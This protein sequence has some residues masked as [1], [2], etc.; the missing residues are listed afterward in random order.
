MTNNTNNIDCIH[1][2]ASVATS[3]TISGVTSHVHACKVREFCTLTESKLTLLDGSPIAVCAT[4]KQ[5][6]PPPTRP[7]ATIPLTIGMATFDDYWG[8]W[9]TCQALHNARIEAGLLNEIE[10][11]VVDNNPDGSHG[12]PTKGQVNSY[13]NAR[14]IEFTDHQG[15]SGPRNKVFEVASG[16]G[17]VVIDPH[18]LFVR[19]VETLRKLVEFWSQPTAPAD[20]YHGPC[21]YDWLVDP[22]GRPSILG[23]HWEPRW[24]SDG[25]FGKWATAEP[26]THSPHAINDPDATPIEVPLNA[27]G[28]FMSARDSW[29][30]F[31]P[32]QRGF[33]AEEGTIHHKYRHH[34]R[35]TFVLPWLQWV[36]RWGKVERVAYGGMEWTR[37]CKNY[38]LSTRDFGW[39]TLGELKPIFVTTE[40][41][42]IT[43][44][45]DPNLAVKGQTRVTES[46]WQAMLQEL[47]LA[48]KGTAASPAATPN[49]VTLLDPDP[50]VRPYELD[51]LASPAFE[52]VSREHR[53][54]AVMCNRGCPSMQSEPVS[55]FWCKAHQASVTLGKRRTD[56]QHCLECPLRKPLNDES[57]DPLVSHVA[58]SIQ[59]ADQLKSRLPESTLAVQGTTSPRV[60][61]LL[62]NL[63]SAPDVRYL[64]VGCWLGALFISAQAGNDVQHSLAV[65]DFSEFNQYGTARES[66][67]ANC[68]THL[69]REP[70]LIDGDANSL[71][72]EE[73][74][75]VRNGPFNVYL[76]DAAHDYQS[77]FNAIVRVWPALADR[78]ILLVDDANL[79][80]VLDATREALKQCGAV[81]RRHWLLPAKFNGDTER[82]WNGLAVAV[83]DKPAHVRN[84]P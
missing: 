4:C 62:N 79:P 27:C 37:R 43:A 59:Q 30:G 71:D 73:I 84:D 21:L 5:Y 40:S 83:I 53:V 44:N 70:R 3:H 13:P 49:V 55:V 9:A 48:P 41:R 10:L 29:L 47:G 8:V 2:T 76:Y 12:K 65:D 17:V 26:Y 74:S 82:W 78:F 81:I 72:F 67:I 66:F 16:R 45:G 7:P 54:G 68:K 14:Y 33:G 61:H 1:R 25:M 20:L 31:H 11:I 63:C 38:L 32:E 52:C 60:R 56:A 24:G 6:S 46:E 69:G 23:T 64:E 34:G 51:Y 36:H 57:L 77:Q 58:W 39:P 28:L 35:T 22:K 15:T 50:G 18:V 19:P 80:G 75:M 42:N